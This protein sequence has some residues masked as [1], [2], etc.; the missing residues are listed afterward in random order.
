MS[1]V[2]LGLDL[3]S[4]D[5][6]SNVHILNCVTCFVPTPAHVVR[7]HYEFVVELLFCPF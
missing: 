6:G 2:V 4:N 5:S 1:L 3:D 7:L